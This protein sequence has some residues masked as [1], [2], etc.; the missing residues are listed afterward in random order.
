MFKWTHVH[1]NESGPETCY[2]CDGVEV[3]RITRRIDPDGWVAF[4]N[5]HRPFEPRIVKQCT[6]FEAGRKGIELWAERHRE[7]LEYEAGRINALRPRWI[8][9]KHK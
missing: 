5:Q 1:A 8:G 9:G 7:R 3:A 4:L 2:R 6:S